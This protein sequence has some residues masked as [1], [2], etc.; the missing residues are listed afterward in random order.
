MLKSTE[1]FHTSKAVM[2]NEI[3]LNYTQNVS[4]NLTENTTPPQDLSLDVFLYGSSRY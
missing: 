4:P 2:Q 1:V 3:N